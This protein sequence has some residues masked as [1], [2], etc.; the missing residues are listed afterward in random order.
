MADT[1]HERGDRLVIMHGMSA[2]VLRGLQRG[3][4]VDPQVGAPI[5]DS[6][7]QGTMVMVGYEEQEKIIHLGKGVSHA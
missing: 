5:A 6:L 2:R 1:E 7:P 3:L 4:P